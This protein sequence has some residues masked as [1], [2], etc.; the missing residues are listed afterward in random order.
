MRQSSQS[1]F[2]DPLDLRDLANLVRQS[3]SL[4]NITWPAASLFNGKHYTE[5]LQDIF[6]NVRIENLWLPCFCISTNLSTNKQVISRR[7]YLWKIIRSS[8]AVPLVFPPV[9]VKGQLY[10]DGGLLNN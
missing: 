1:P 3:I 10:I 4:K 2:E 5:K 6:R 7:G 8:T 9:V